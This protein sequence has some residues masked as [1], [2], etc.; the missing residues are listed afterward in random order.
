MGKSPG[1]GNFRGDSTYILELR[2]VKFFRF[3]GDKNVQV[4]F[5]T[6]NTF[7]RLNMGREIEAT[8]D[9]S[10][11]GMWTGNTEVG[12]QQFQMQLGVRFTF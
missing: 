12:L 11:F 9:S 6:F 1:R 10:N 4:M 7:N 5:E 3:G 8:F 2:I